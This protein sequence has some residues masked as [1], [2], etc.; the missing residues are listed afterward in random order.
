[1]EKQT[2]WCDEDVA[3][4]VQLPAEETAEETTEETAATITAGET[5]LAEFVRLGSCLYVPVTSL[6]SAT[7]QRDG[8]QHEVDEGKL[9]VVALNGLIGCMRHCQ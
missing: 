1:M 2:A 5:P 8:P 3:A 7:L 6:R 9:A 4:G